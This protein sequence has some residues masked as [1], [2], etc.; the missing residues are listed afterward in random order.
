MVSWTSVRRN[1]AREQVSRSTRGRR[2]PEELGEYRR[3]L[4]GVVHTDLV[5]RVTRAAVQLEHLASPVA[6]H[7]TGLSPG[8]RALA[9][10]SPG[11]GRPVWRARPGSVGRA[12]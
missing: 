12:V 10:W 9:S 7:E 11:A 6:R 8:S 1:C 3:L 5:E 2:W 4:R